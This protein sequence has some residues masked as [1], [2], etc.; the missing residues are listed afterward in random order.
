[1]APPIYFS[2]TQWWVDTVNDDAN[3][4]IETILREGARIVDEAE[5][6]FI[7]GTSVSAD[8]KRTIIGE[9][10][11]TEVCAMG[12]RTILDGKIGVSSTN[13]P[14]RWRQ[15]LNSA[16]ESGSLAGPQE[17]HGLPTRAEFEQEV[18]VFDPSITPDV[19]IASDLLNQ[20]LVFL[21]FGTGKLVEAALAADMNLRACRIASM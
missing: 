11:S 10:T 3:A 1:M 9:A 2:I 12:I 7:Q 14:Y 6:F 17:W 5:V 8:L 4:L 20:M 13:D 21:L 15:C 19:A 16:V 18:S